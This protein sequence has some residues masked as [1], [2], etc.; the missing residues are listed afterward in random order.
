MNLQNIDSITEKVNIYARGVLAKPR[1]DHS[2]RVAVLC[3]DLC[4]RFG[5]NPKVGYLAGIAHDMCKA[6]KDRWLVALASQDGTAISD[7]EVSKPALLHGRAAAM[8][9]STDFGVDDESILG[10]VRHHT[11]GAPGLDG[12]GMILFVADKVE[13]GRTDYDPE[14][15]KKILSQNLDGM[16]RLVLED[17][18]KYL[19]SKKKEVSM[20]TLAMLEEIEGRMNP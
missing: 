7:I 6:G 9:L 10:A 5:L 3:R 13:P 17:N 19:E 12:I 18:I 8:L 11:F 2:V 15:R 16:T 4:E 1:Y 14:R 20:A